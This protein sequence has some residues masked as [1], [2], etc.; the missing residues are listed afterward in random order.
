MRIA[1]SRYACL[2][3]WTW[4]VQGTVKPRVVGVFLGGVEGLTINCNYTLLHNADDWKKALRTSPVMVNR[5]HWGGQRRRQE[6]MSW[7][8]VLVWGCGGV[9][10]GMDLNEF[11]LVKYIRNVFFKR[12]QEQERWT[13]NFS[14]ERWAA[15]MQVFFF[16]MTIMCLCK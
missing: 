12:T 7:V 10:G 1:Q 3:A 14:Q 2:Y 9:K 5:W 15:F 4:D 13:E 8:C 16:L 11:F 6:G